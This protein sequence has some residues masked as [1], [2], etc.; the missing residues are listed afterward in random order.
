MVDR[1]FNEAAMR[2]KIE[3]A[4]KER[5]AK[6]YAAKVARIR[7]ELANG[8]RVISID[9]PLGQSEGELS[10]KWLRA[11]MPT[12]GRDV[13]LQVHSEGGS[14]FEALSMI[15]VLNA[16]SG[17]VKAIVSSMALSAASLIL[18]AAD[19]IEVTKNSYVMLHDSHMEN[20]EEL[21][22]TERGLLASLNERMVELYS[23]RTR[24]PANEIRR[25]MQAETFLG[26]DDAVRLGFADR[27]VDA[28]RL[29]IVARAI[30]KRIVAKAKSPTTNATA[31]WRAAVD[32]AATKMPRAKAIMEVDRTNPGLRAAM[33]AEVNRR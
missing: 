12:D 33:L 32:S 30:P 27:V 7:A 24:Q 16:Y 18:S 3:Q 6:A 23:A 4:R 21:T 9:A 26:A 28:S 11:Q 2:R 10:A 25:L 19:E 22:D 17:R 15:D 8:P 20:D 5:E 31:R 13:V 14:I 1:S 29:Q